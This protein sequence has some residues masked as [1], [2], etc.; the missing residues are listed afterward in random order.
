M[1]RVRWGQRKGR[2]VQGLG[3]RWGGVGSEQRQRGKG[4]AEVGD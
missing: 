2:G 1:D 4:G 3:F